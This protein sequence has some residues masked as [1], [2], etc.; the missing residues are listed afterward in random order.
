MVRALTIAAALGLA[1]ALAGSAQATV[2]TFTPAMDL[3]VDADAGF[4]KADN[5]QLDI[6]DGQ[7]GAGQDNRALLKFDFS[8]IAGATVHGA[9]LT[10]NQVEL[11]NDDR[12]GQANLRRIGTTDWNG[13]EP[14]NVLYDLARDANSVSIAN[15]SPPTNPP[16]GPYNVD[17]T[18]VVQAWVG[19]SIPNYGLSLVQLSEGFTDTQ[20][21]FVSGNAGGPAVTVDFT[22]A[23]GAPTFT[24]L[25]PTTDLYIDVDAGFAK[26]D[27]GQL[28]VGDGQGGAGQDDRALL[29]FDLSSL[30]GGTIH[31]ATLI[32]NQVDMGSGDRW[33]AAQLR[34][35]ATMDWDGTELGTVLYDLARDANSVFITNFSPA[36]DPPP[37]PYHMDVTALVQGWADGS[38][39][40]YGLGL[41]QGS[42]GFTGTQ[43]RF[44][45]ADAGD[46]GPV[47][48]VAFTPIPE[49]ATL[50]LLGLGLTALARRRR[51]R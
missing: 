44:S 28:D 10:L 35:I 21:R 25:T 2:F 3:Y 8:L 34:R 22:A 31:G 50:A 5:N 23:P 19:G 18:P 32:L 15:F 20:R 40:N 43:R 27:D 47:L 36:T 42:E 45:S 39:P 49:P 41:M 14:G 17:V 51:R 12:Y 46:G 48:Y 9:T 38:F 33:G 29:K 16:P 24:T 26:V 6:G 13:T 4:A 30:A 1:L 37:G 11:G 7:G